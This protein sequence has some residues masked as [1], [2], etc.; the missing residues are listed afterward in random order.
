MTPVREPDAV[1]ADRGPRRLPA[2]PRRRRA[3][4]PRPKASTCCSRRRSTR[5]TRRPPRTT[6]HVDGLTERPVRREPPGALRRRHHGR[7]EAVLDRR[8]VPRVLRPQGRAAARGRS[9]AWPPTSTC[10]S[11]CVGCPLVREPDGLAMSSRNAYLDRRRAAPRRRCCRA[12]CA[13]SADAVRGRRAR[14][15]A[16]AAHRPSSRSWQRAAGRR[17]TTPR[18]STRATLEPVE[19]RSTATCVVAVAAYVGRAR[20]IDNVGLAVDPATVAST[21]GPRRRRGRECAGRP[22]GVRRLSP[23]TDLLVLGSGVAGLSAAVRA[24][25]RGLLGRRAHQG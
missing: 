13:P 18:S 24:A 20:L 1:R 12:R 9:G 23:M 2:R 25:R 17:S 22:L 11:T 3:R 14:R 16:I 21:V 8:A 19:R 4:S 5:C 7:R 10:R 6:V 15:R